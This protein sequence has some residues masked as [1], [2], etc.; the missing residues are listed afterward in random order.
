MRKAF[1][2]LAALVLTLAACSTAANPGTPMPS[3][4]PG[5]ETAAPATPAV[6]GPP[7]VYTDWSKLE[8]RPAALPRVGTRWYAAYTDKLLP[9]EDYGALLPYAGL[10]LMSNWPADARYMYGLMTADG[11]AVTDAVFSNVDRLKLEDG[12]LLVLSRGDGVRDDRWGPRRLA[13]AAADGRW[14][15]GF[16]YHYYSR[17]R[18]GLLLFEEDGIAL[19]NAQGEI[20]LR[21]SLGELGLTEEEFQ[22]MVSDVSWSIGWGG[23]WYG[24]YISLGWSDDERTA[25]RVYQISSA[26]Q[27]VFT[28]DEWY[29]REEAEREVPRDEWQALSAPGETVLT[30]GEER[31]TIPYGGE[32]T[33]VEVCGELALFHPSNAVYTLEGEELLPAMEGSRY[34]VKAEDGAPVLVMTVVYGKDGREKSSYCR[35]D[36]EP[37]P[38][39]DGWGNFS[40]LHWYRQIKVVGG[41]LEVLD[42]NTASYYEIDTLNCVFRTQLGYDGD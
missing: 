9:R 30:R 31:I 19:M 36:G 27:T 38:M 37:I 3:P 1:P 35:P 6:T 2:L 7:A 29:G 5:P 17:S 8:P 23:R 21:R 33:W 4:S 16:D 22:S 40:D 34:F 41:L 18:Q 14:C 11:V 26:S 28:V 15:T 32:E 42:L 24:D 12:A 13:V 39:L 20:F 10:R 25:V